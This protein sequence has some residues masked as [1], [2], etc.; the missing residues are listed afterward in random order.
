MKKSILTV[1]CFAITLNAHA[2]LVINVDFHDG[3]GKPTDDYTAAGMAGFWN[4]L[5]SDLGDGIEILD[6]AGEATGISISC[7]RSLGAVTTSHQSTD[8][9]DAAL[10]RDYLVSGYNDFDLTIFGLEANQ[11]DILVYALGRQDYPYGTTVT[12]NGDVD[13]QKYMTG[14][15][16]GSLIEG[17]THTKHRVI[18]NND[19]IVLS[20]DKSSD[21]ITNGFQII[22]VPEPATLLLLGLG[23]VMVKKRRYKRFLWR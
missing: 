22:Q 6:G 19:P 10:L 15:W 13:N 5:G 18:V 3:N 8:G 4:V 20:I 17:Q 23:V 21:A 1:L 16:T 12:I 11:Y 7:S 2:G 14:I 9:N